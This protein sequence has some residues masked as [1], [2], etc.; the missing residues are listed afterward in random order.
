MIEMRRILCPIDFSDFSRRALDHAVAIAK[1]YDSTI[2]LLH[3]C[4]VVPAAAY[5][6]G[7]GVLPSAAPTPA[8]RDALF[9]AMKRFAESE[10]GTTVPIEFDGVEGSTV[11]EILAKAEAMPADLLVMGTHGRSGFERLVLGSVTEKVLRKAVCP[12]LTVPGIMSDVVP[13]PGVLFK[14]I[15][16]AI[17]FSDCSMHALN[18]AMSLA[19][20][21]DAR[22]TVVHVI[23]LPTDVVRE[24]R[25]TVPAGPR[26]L[27]E[28]ITLTEVDRR[29]RL[30]EAV[31]ESVR[32]YCTVDT[33]LPTGKAYR[34]ILRVVDERKADLLVIGIHGR[35]VVDRMLFGS[36]AQHLVRQ[37]SCPVLTLRKG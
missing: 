23:E 4:A 33:L 31:P 18:Y 2:T 6:P 36:T 14:N 13:V 9:A 3:V 32:A 16:C 1:W 29:A 30:K 17:D 24:V 7:S 27:Q 12:V 15:V 35:G 10:A 25:E 11:A 34:E 5:A 21:A 19:Q 8:D 20:E 28:Y 37:T 22:L 26:N